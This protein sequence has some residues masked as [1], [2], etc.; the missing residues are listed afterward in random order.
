[1]LDEAQEQP[2]DCEVTRIQIQEHRAGGIVA[3]HC[4]GRNARALRELSTLGR[5]DKRLPIA[6]PGMRPLAQANR[7]RDCP[8]GDPAVCS[9]TVGYRTPCGGWSSGASQAASR[10]RAFCT[11]GRAALGFASGRARR[12]TLAGLRAI[13]IASPVAGLRP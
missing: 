2:D 5:D 8:R 13:V 9:L 7:H 4:L 11:L 3:N 10:R 1:V 6:V 12:S